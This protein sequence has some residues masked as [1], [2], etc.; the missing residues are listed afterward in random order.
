MTTGRRYICFQ[1]NK[2]K[3]H[4]I[5]AAVAEEEEKTRRGPLLNDVNDLTSS[6]WMRFGT[7]SAHADLDNVAPVETCPNQ[8]R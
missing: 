3:Y 5:M 8:G 6:E 7:C 1:A 4:A 2:A